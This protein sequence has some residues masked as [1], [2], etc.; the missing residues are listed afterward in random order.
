MEDK[1]RKMV[2][3]TDEQLIK[4]FGEEIVTKLRHLQQKR[5]DQKIINRRKQLGDKL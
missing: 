3:P 5:R 1:K 4:L 2:S